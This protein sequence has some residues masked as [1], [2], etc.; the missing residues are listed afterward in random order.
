MFSKYFYH[1][2]TKKI[3][4]AFGSL[5]NNITVVRRDDSSKVLQ[6]VRCPISYGPRH[7]WLTRIKE[8]PDL[9]NKLSEVAIRLP[10]MSFEITSMNVDDPAKLNRTNTHQVPLL[11]GG[12]A[13]ARQMVPYM[14][15]MQLSIYAKNQNDAL[16]ILE[17]IIPYF[18][19][20]HTLSIFDLDGTSQSTDVPITLQSVGIQDDYEGDALT[21]RAIVYTLDF[22]LRVKFY[23]PLT[24]G[25]SGIIR[26]TNIHF[27]DNTTGTPRYL[28]TMTTGVANPADTK[29]SHT[30]IARTTD[31]IAEST[32]YSV[33]L[34]DIV[35]AFTSG[36]PVYTTL[37]GTIGTLQSISGASA[38]I[39]AADGVVILDEYVVGK[40]SGAYG[41]VTAL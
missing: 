38:V 37:T 15:G 36:E 18:S 29:E 2:S 11:E 3:V 25:A 17:Q 35:G 1:S 39:V 10:R 40:T 8:E 27:Q 26:T 13:R 14:I 34:S 20:D 28:E 24:D 12:T 32:E 22:M 16:Q 7:K 9:V 19:P 23:G 5:F 6:T 4:A 33:T 41:K 30:I 21:R 31:F